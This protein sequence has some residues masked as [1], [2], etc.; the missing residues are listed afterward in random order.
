MSDV[1]SYFRKHGIWFRKQSGHNL[2]FNCPDCQRKRKAQINAR[3]WLWQCHSAKCDAKGNEF[4]LKKLM[5]HAYDVKSQSGESIEDIRNKQFAEA[6]QR[7][8]AAAT[9]VDR[10]HLDLLNSEAAAKARDYLASRGLKRDTW[11]MAKL[12]FIEQWPGQKA[13]GRRIGRQTAPAPSDGYLTIP[14]LTKP[15][16][17]TS[18]SM[19]KVRTLGDVSKDGRYRRFAGGRSILYAP[20]GI[21][22]NETLLIVGGE[23][24]ALS[25]IQAGY[26][27]VVASTT[28]EHNWDDVFTKQVESVEDVVV[29]YD[30]DD[31]GR[32][33]A[34]M[35]AQTLGIHRCRI[36]SWPEGIE[37]ANAALQ[38]LGTGWDIFKIQEILRGAKNLD[39]AG[40][41]APSELR[42]RFH[43]SFNVKGG[44]RGW[45]TGWSDL[46]NL[47]GGW[48]VSEV[49]V[50]TGGTGV[51]KTTFS[52]QA[53]LYQASQGRGVLYCPFEIGP[54]R[55]LKK[56]VRQLSTESPVDMTYEARDQW[57]TKIANLPLWLFYHRGVIQPEAMRNTILYARKRLGVR[58]VVIDHVHAMVTQGPEQWSQLAELSKMLFE[59][60][61]DAMVHV[62]TLAHPA[63]VSSGGKDRRDRD[64]VVVQMSDIKGVS[65]LSQDA[66]LVI[67]MWRP[68]DAERKDVIGADGMGTSVAF[69]QKAR[70]EE[71]S[72]GRVPFRFWPKAALMLDKNPTVTRVTWHD[73]YD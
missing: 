53:A 59:V 51:G 54:V 62:M 56:W 46:D 32:Q 34:L 47:I 11:K 63:K 7:R 55:Q 41:V 14:V 27:N 3:T 31:A 2:E 70:D 60:A 38:K 28:G 24:D 36:G 72:E 18:C 64:N 66:D 69:V 25:V 42:D 8:S 57:V 40:M 29:I 39:I 45:P 49:T 37:D 30:N 16:D 17:A 23:L 65:N 52:S 73:E 21:N 1:E 9:D 50:V 12:G 22:P 44:G 35:V 48:R 61:Q 4:T 5:G 68:R 15:G 33:G 6:M 26:D 58:F 67:S 19:T 13:Q 71:S 10:H 43:A 20:K